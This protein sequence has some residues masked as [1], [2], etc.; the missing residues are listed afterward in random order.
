M[1]MHGLDAISARM[2]LLNYETAITSSNSNEL[3][4]RVGAHAGLTR[5]EMAPLMH[6]LT[7]WVSSILDRLSHLLKAFPRLSSVCVVGHVS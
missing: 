2:L 4:C 5:Q 1:G 6:L 7:S 3:L